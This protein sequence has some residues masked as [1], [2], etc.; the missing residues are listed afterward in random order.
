MKTIALCSKYGTAVEAALTFVQADDAIAMTLL[1]I[2]LNKSG[3]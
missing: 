1:G 3:S 2:G